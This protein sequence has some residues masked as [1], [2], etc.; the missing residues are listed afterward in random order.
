MRTPQYFAK[1]MKYD[2]QRTVFR[3]AQKTCGKGFLGV[4]LL[5][6][7]K[8]ENFYPGVKREPDDETNRRNAAALSAT[9][10]VTVHARLMRFR[11]GANRRRRPRPRRQSACRSRR[12][13]G[14]RGPQRE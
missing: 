9:A 13:H 3:Y 4:K 11:H 2:A 12:A 8:I 1:K 10:P 5:F 14:V 7:I 6:L